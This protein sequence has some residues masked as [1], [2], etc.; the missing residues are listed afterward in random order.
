V[1]AG[2]D[3]VEFVLFGIEQLRDEL[4]VGFLVAG[5]GAVFAIEGDIEQGPS[6]CCRAIDLRISFSEPA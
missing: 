6:S 5:A 3:A 2:A 1:H 4:G